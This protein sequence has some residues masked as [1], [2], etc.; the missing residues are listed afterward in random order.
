MTGPVVTDDL[1][2]GAVKWLMDQP[3]IVAVLGTFPGTT[4]PYLFQHN[5]WARIEG[6]QST[7]AVISRAGGWAGAN[8]HNTLRFPRLSL[9]LYADPL[10]DGARMVIEPVETWRRIEAAFAVF[11]KV[12]HQPAA[13]AQMW[14]TVRAIGCLRQGEPIVYPVPDGDGVLRLQT[15]YG[16]SQ[17]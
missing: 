6:T 8:P 5:L 11:D 1:V 9:E 10:R 15:F 13:S 7:A 14:G 4:T 3:A 2:Q 16:V 12:L 17:G